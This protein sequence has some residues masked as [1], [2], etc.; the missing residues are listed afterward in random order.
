LGILELVESLGGGVE[1]EFP[2]TGMKGRKK[3]KGRGFL[4]FA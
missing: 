1:V 2:T 3:E 4:C